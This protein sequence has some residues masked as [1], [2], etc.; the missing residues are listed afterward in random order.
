MIKV[1][2]DFVFAMRCEWWVSV[3]NHSA[4][5]PLEP[6][7]KGMQHFETN[8][9]TF[10]WKHSMSSLFHGNE[11]Q[12]QSPGSCGTAFFQATQSYAQLS[13]QCIVSAPRQQTFKQSRNNKHDSIKRCAVIQLWAFGMVQKHIG[14]SLIFGSLQR[15]LHAFWPP[16]DLFWHAGKKQ[17][18]QQANSW[19]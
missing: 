2:E 8:S 18:M 9:L 16:E 19:W 12:T 6:L 5:K 4:G 15:I 14:F 11:E 3:S 13:W 7:T 10:K 17:K 1:A